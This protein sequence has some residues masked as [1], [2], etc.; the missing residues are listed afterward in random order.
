[1]VYLL[2][3][4]SRLTSDCISTQHLIHT[5]SLFLGIGNNPMVGCTVLVRLTLLLLS[6]NKF[7]SLVASKEY[8]RLT[9]GLCLCNY[10]RYR[11]HFHKESALGTPKFQ[12]T[13]C[14]FAPNCTWSPILHPMSDLF[15]IGRRC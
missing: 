9:A 12:G 4:F 6:T 11:A 15:R 7:V 10:L 2:F 3:L 8:A 14:I 5:S 13:A 1:M